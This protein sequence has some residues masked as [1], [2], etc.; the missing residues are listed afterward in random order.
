M[1]VIQRTHETADFVEG[2]R[3]AQRAIAIDDKEASADYA[4]AFYYASRGETHRA[5]YRRAPR[6]AHQVYG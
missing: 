1:L 4:I 6:Q 5:D 3:S 2:E